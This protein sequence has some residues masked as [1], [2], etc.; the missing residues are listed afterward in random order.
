MKAVENS[1]T[2][3]ICAPAIFSIS[4]QDL[5]EKI[6]SVVFGVHG[7]RRLKQ[8]VAGTNSVNISAWYFIEINKVE[9]TSKGKMIKFELFTSVTRLKDTWVEYSTFIMQKDYSTMGWKELA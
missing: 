5:V 1:S 6:Q 2:V 8:K 7:N 9:G 3:T 4:I